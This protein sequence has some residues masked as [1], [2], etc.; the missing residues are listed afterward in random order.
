VAVIPSLEQVRAWH[1][2][3]VVNHLLVSGERIYEFAMPDWKIVLA[4]EWPVFLG[5]VLGAMFLAAIGSWQLAA[6]VLLGC[7]AWVLWRALVSWYTRYVLTNFRVMR[8]DGV[9]SRNVE[10]IPWRKVTDVSLRRSAF[11]R[12]VGASTIRIESANE[13]S[14]FRGMSDVRNPTA[15]FSTLQELMAAF[16]VPFEVSTLGEVYVPRHGPASGETAAQDDLYDD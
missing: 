14:Q 3:E 13:A 15:F 4:S 5:G 1:P 7:G 16:S 11:Q 2:E 8:V 10:F 6:L 9:L 12:A